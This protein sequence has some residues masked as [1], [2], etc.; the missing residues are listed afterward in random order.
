MTEGSTG[1]W[2][3]A[4]PA[5]RS[6]TRAAS[7]HDRSEGPHPPRFSQPARSLRNSRSAPLGSAGEPEM[8]F[9]P[10][11]YHLRGGCSATELLRRTR[12]DTNGPGR[13]RY[14]CCHHPRSAGSPRWLAT[15]PRRHDAPMASTGT[16]AVGPVHRVMVGTDRSET[17]DE[18]GGVGG[19]VRRAVRRRAP[20]RAGDRPG[21]RRPTPS[22]GPP[23]RPG[24][25]APPTSCRST[26]RSSR[27]SAG[28]RTS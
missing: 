23:R 24:R 8:G 9:E 18:S 3:S 27:E 20:R 13:G 19:L 12:Q 4:A 25:T 14:E 17:A 26:R 10:M 28:T 21:A 16:D 5:G 22:T 6:M 2:A 11:T 7:K 1:V 15:D